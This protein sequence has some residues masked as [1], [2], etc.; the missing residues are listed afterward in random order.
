MAEKLESKAWD[1]MSYAEKTE[2]VRV[3]KERSRTQKAK[4][5]KYARRDLVKAHKEEY[6]GLVAMY[7]EV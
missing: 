7:M 2:V 1:N 5:I 3:W 6:D 4:A